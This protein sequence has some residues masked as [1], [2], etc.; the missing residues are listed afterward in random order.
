MAVPSSGQLRLRGDLA[1][2]VNGSASGTNVSLSSLSESAGLSAPHNMS[3]LYGYT[4]AVAPSAVANSASSVGE[5]TMT[6]H[7]NITSDGNASITERGFYFGT[8]PRG[9]SYNPKYVVGGTTGSFSLSRSGLYAGSA[10]YIWA[11][12][13]N[14]VGTTYSSRVT[15]ATIAAFIPFWAPVSTSN[16]NSGTRAYLSAGFSGYDYRFR[17]YLYYLNPNTGSF[18][19]RHYYTSRPPSG[20]ATVY[21]NVNQEY[22]S[23]KSIGSDLGMMVTNAKNRWAIYADQ[24]SVSPHPFN[25]FQFNVTREGSRT[26]SNVSVNSFSYTYDYS[27]STKVSGRPFIYSGNSSASPMWLYADFNYN[28]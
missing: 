28:N 4:S 26:F 21:W 22:S 15:Q 8:N 16:S 7:G 23:N 17:S 3:E 13:T 14:S 2:E 1:L 24:F 5:T 18:V 20:K 25:V 9:P 27:N 10:Y 11:F 12:A 6:I 19:N